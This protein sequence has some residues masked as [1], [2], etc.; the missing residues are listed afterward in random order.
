[1]PVLWSTPSGDA[2]GNIDSYIEMGARIIGALEQT[3]IA[4]AA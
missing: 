4:T 2:V 1:V 3:E